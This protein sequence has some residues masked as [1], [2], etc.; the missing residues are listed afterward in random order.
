MSK[1]RLP[2]GQ[3]TSRLAPCVKGLLA[4]LKDLP[5]HSVAERK[6]IIE[7]LDFLVRRCFIRNHG[8]VRIKPLQD[9]SLS[10]LII[11][12]SCIQLTLDLQSGLATSQ[13]LFAFKKVNRWSKSREKKELVSGEKMNVP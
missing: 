8:K 7:Y 5:E 11:A 12:R 1:C 3:L 10:H 6:Q 4:V 13:P 2:V 9:L